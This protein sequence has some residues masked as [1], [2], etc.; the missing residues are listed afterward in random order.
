MKELEIKLT[1]RQ[2]RGETVVCV[3]DNPVAFKKNKFGNLVCNYQTEHDKVNIKVYRLLDVGGVVWFFIQLFFF[4][5][6]IFGLLDI[7]RR[8]RCM[9]IDFEADVD[10]N[11]NSSVTLQVNSPKEN[12]PAITVQTDLVCVEK[13]NEYFVDTKSR[14]ILKGLRLTKLFLALAIIGSTIAILIL[15]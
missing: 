11:Q 5:I 7:R 12:E 10:L 4:V 13:S 9:V 3:D 1:G 6:S 14:K 8:E 2:R 15:K